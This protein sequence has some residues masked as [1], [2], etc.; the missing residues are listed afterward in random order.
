MGKMLKT[1]GILLGLA[2]VLSLGVW[3]QGASQ[4]RH[5]ISNTP[6]P[7][8][9]LLLSLGITVSPPGSTYAVSQTAAER[10]AL[11]K[12]PMIAPPVKSVPPMTAE[13]LTVVDP[14]MV[15]LTHPVDVWLVTF[16]IAVSLPGPKGSTPH[17]AHH[18]TELINAETGH[19]IVTFYWN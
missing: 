17:V 1:V 19:V 11:S 9:H 16:N 2:G 7:S 10:I 13:R 8:Q 14:H 15:V 4:S 6:N 5:P 12:L 3:V 18:E